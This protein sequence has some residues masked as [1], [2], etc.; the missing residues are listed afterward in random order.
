MESRRAI[1]KKTIKVFTGAF[2]FLNPIFTF[3]R[4]GYAGIKK[5]VLPQNTKMVD[6]IDE[7]PS[8]L[9]ISQL[10][11]TPIIEFDTMGQTEHT[12]D[13]KKW[14]LEI[15][16]DVEEDFD[17]TYQDVF[18]FPEIIKKVLLICP[19]FF[20]LNGKWKGISMGP[21]LTSLKLN[22]NAT[23]VRFTGPKGRLQETEIY[24]LDELYSNKVFLAYE[25]NDKPLSM[26]HGYPL[27]IVANGYFGSSWIK[28]VD[29][30]RVESLSG[31]KKT[32]IWSDQY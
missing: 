23:H 28:Y 22:K 3:V 10:P 21:F 20:A 2:L 29:Q 18:K 5:N 11:V 27:R 19:G 31:G 7:D 12:V 24:P 30:V 14:R 6:L 1:I 32:F 17:L 15:T 4:R 26:K 9:D 8:E 16:G 13:L 25:V